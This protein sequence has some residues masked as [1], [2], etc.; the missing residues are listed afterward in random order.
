MKH[1]TAILR[2]VF[3]TLATIL[4]ISGFAITL[5]EALPYL[6]CKDGYA[7][8]F[9]ARD[10]SGSRRLY[11]LLH[12]GPAIVALM[13][14]P[15]Q[16]SASMREFAPRLHRING[17]IYVSCV[18]ISG[19][20]S[21]VLAPHT[22]GG[23]S[24]GLGFG[25]LAA[26]WLIATSTALGA[27]IRRKFLQHQLWMLRSYVLTC[28]GVIFRIQLM[29]LEGVFNWQFEDAYALAAWAC[30]LPTLIVLEIWIQTGPASDNVRNQK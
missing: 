30:W 20:T 25:I 24:N 6:F 9:G 19:T 29:I 1:L 16:L 2:Q 17:W 4:I 15:F 10:P 11:A 28:C 23:G 22:N 13:I 26:L 27:V 7:E 12:I 14:G 18:V 5:A 3:M 21:L 8:F